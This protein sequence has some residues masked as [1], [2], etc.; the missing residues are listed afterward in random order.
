ME[1]NS[2][3]HTMTEHIDESIGFWFKEMIESYTEE[4]VKDMPEH[5]DRNEFI[6]DRICG[7]CIS[8]DRFMAHD[9]G[10][11]PE[12][13]FYHWYNSGP[14]NITRLRYLSFDDAVKMLNYTARFNKLW[15]P[16]QE[17]PF[18]TTKT[19]EIINDYALAYLN[20]KMCGAKKTYYNTLLNEVYEEDL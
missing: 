2:I 11:G 20:K 12:R 5:Q 15:W 18:K 4:L 13:N 3:E 17:R 14:D 7:H 16:D 19:S 10:A 6:W 8:H 9:Y 1:H